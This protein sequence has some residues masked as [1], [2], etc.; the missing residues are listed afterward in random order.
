MVLF[1]S[2]F[3]A[4]PVSAASTGTMVSNAVQASFGVTYYKGWTKSTDH[5]NHYVT[6]T[7]AEQGIVTIN[8]TK[9]FDSKGE[10]GRLY[11]TVYDSSFNAIWGND[12]YQSVDDVR[13]SYNVKVGLAA[14]TY[15][16]TLRPGFYVSSGVIET[17]YTLSFQANPYC[18]VE[19]NGDGSCATSV[20]QGVKY[21]GYYGAAGND[22]EEADYYKMYVKAGTYRITWYN[23][24]AM[25]ATSTIVELLLPDGDDYS[26][27]YYLKSHIT[28]EGLNYA[29][30]TVKQSGMAYL[31][32]YNSSRA[33]FEY[34]FSITNIYCATNGHRYGSPAVTRQPGCTT[35]GVKTYTCTTCGGT[36]TESVAA[37]GHS[38]NSGA[39]TTQPT[40]T[41]TGVKT[42]TCTN[43]KGTRTE[44]VAV[45]GHSWNS[46]AITKQP[47]CTQSGVKTYT[48]NSCG[49]TKTETVR[50]RHSYTNSADQYCNA[51]NWKKEANTLK[52]V[53]GVWKYYEDGIFTDVT[54]LVKF[55]GSWYYVKNGV[56]DNS[57][58]GLFKFNGSWFYVY[59]G[60]VASNT[61]T[62]VKYNGEWFYVVN[63]KVASATT[64]LVKF[65]GEWFY[66]VKGKV[67]SNTTT[68]VKY[69][70]G[71]YYIYKG[72]LA[73]K[74]T[75]LVKYSGSWY[76]V[77]NGKVDFSYSGRFLFNGAYYTVK[78]GRVV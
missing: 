38:W 31:H 44:S 32:I 42:Y 54:T 59:K 53:D 71:W 7:L 37:K 16:L 73:S 40:C 70:G 21:T 61:T 20:Q 56:V 25:D 19:P 18:E 43:C 57:Y 14:G 28:N 65:N 75:T 62:L 5:L 76:Y 60:R 51:C 13:D 49:T 33:Q 74:T 69:N 2:A 1:V 55:S 34:G 41:K 72:K 22:Y 9:P 46:G 24:R 3:A 48:C 29:D 47:T 64:T 50:P 8:A 36:K 39:I 27:S 15:Y 12:S 4:V 78:N 17:N 35:A 58:T 66:V 52:K 23:F 11:F 45:K 67:A 77:K 6:F 10:Y 68:L 63:G 30:V 26:V